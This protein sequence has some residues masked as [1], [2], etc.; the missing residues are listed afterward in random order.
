MESNAVRDLKHD[1]FEI[2][3]NFGQKPNELLATIKNSIA[4]IPSIRRYQEL[5]LDVLQ[6][7]L[8]NNINDSDDKG[9]GIQKLGGI[10]IY[11]YKNHPSISLYNTADDATWMWLVYK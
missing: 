8:I 1:V 6:D 9:G 3:A 5:V 2:S 11:R 7:A 10:L 4:A